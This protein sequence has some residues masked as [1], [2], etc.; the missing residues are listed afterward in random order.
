[1]RIQGAL[2]G[3]EIA[4]LTDDELRHAADGVT[5]FSR[6]TP[7]QKQRIIRA[8]REN[9]HVVAYMGDG[10]NDVLSL[11]EADV[12]I[13]VQNAVDVAKQTAD[14]ILLKKGFHEIIEGIMEGRKTFANTF[15][16]L[17]MALS[18]NFGNMFSMP[19]ASLIFP[20]LPMTAPQI[21]LNNFLYDSSQLAIPFDNVDEDFLTR[22]KKFNVTFLKKFMII[23]GPLSSCFDFATFGF[24]WIML[25]ATGGMFQ[26]GWFLES[27]ATQTLVVNLIRSRAAFWKSKPSK[28]L[29]M[30]TFGAVALAWVLPYTGL[31]HRLGFVGLGAYPLVAIAGIVVVYLVA[32]EIAKKYFYRKYGWLIEK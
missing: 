12:S 28:A 23:F 11:K 25:H 17:Q 8:L 14:I 15:K 10:V 22:P 5:I 30:S 18:S 20:F 21:L 4:K 3:D 1:M 24:L 29:V 2:T 16:Y 31:G 19:V 7:E 9:G 6:V 26:T 32:V 13:S 27:I